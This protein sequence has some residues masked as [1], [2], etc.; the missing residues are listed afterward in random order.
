MSLC[1]RDAT[2]RVARSYIFKPKISIWV[3]FGRSCNRRC[4]YILWPFGPFY[5]Y[6]VYFSVI[7]Y[8]LWSFGIFLP[9]LVVPKQIWQ[10]WATTVN[11]RHKLFEKNTISYCINILS[12][13][14]DTP[15]QVV[16]RVAG[17]AYFHTKNANLGIFECRVG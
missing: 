2:T 5:G 16:S 8:I 9:V 13:S 3:V 4:W 15:L 17:L 1:Q 11:F 12:A 10:P 6:W 14:K 7:Y